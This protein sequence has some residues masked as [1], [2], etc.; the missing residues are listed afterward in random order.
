MQIVC[1]GNLYSNLHTEIHLENPNLDP[2]K[3]DTYPSTKL[4]ND[5]LSSVI[6]YS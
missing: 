1:L 6:F 4:V 2:P 3:T 5:C